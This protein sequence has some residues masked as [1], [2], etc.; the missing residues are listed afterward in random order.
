[1]TGSRITKGFINFR[2]EV[3]GWSQGWRRGQRAGG[4]DKS[5]NEEIRAAFAVIIQSLS[6]RW[7]QGKE[8]TGQQRSRPSGCILSVAALS[9]GSG[10]MRGMGGGAELRSRSRRMG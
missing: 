8:C 7:S 5:R 10:G 2:K 9:P 1:M 6:L 3:K 4:R